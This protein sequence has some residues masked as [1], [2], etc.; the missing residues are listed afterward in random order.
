MLA[1]ILEGDFSA[2]NTTYE[3][4]LKFALSNYDKSQLEFYYCIGLYL[5]GEKDLLKEHLSL[6]KEYVSKIDAYIEKNEIALFNNLLDGKA[7]LFDGLVH[8]ENQDIYKWI[9]FAKDFFKSVIKA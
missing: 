3:H 7:D 2:M 6:A 8:M 5:A 4:A 9:S 1:D